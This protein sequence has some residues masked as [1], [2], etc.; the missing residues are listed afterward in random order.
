ML[1]NRN[2]FKSLELEQ[3][4]LKFLEDLYNHLKDYNGFYMAVSGVGDLEILEL[5]PIAP[6]SFNSD[7]EENYI[8]DPDG[9]IKDKVPQKKEN[10]RGADTL[11]KFQVFE[12]F[13][14]RNTLI[15]TG[16]YFE[17][18]RLLLQKIMGPDEL[19]APGQKSNKIKS[20]EEVTFENETSLSISDEMMKKI[21][22]HGDPDSISFEKFIE[23]LEEYKEAFRSRLQVEEKK[24]T[25]KKHCSDRFLYYLNKI[26]NNEDLTATAVTKTTF[27]PGERT[28][29]GM[30]GCN[31]S[32]L[33][34]G[35]ELNI[36]AS[37]CYAENLVAKEV[38]S[39]LG[40]TLAIEIEELGEKFSPRSKQ[41]N[42]KVGEIR[43]KYKLDFTNEIKI[44]L[45]SS[46]TFEDVKERIRKK[47]EP[48]KMTALEKGTLF[49]LS[50][51]TFIPICTAVGVAAG[52]GAGL[53]FPISIPI[54]L[55]IGG[56]VGFF[57][58]VLVGSI[59]GVTAIINLDQ[60]NAKEEKGHE[61]RKDS[62]VGK[63]RADIESFFLENAMQVLDDEKLEEPVE[64]EN[65]SYSGNTIK[66]RVE[67]K[68]GDIKDESTV[69]VGP[70]YKP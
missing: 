65:V 30:Y 4:K 24:K 51:R 13:N 64:T 48:S 40:T 2:Q 46:P 50:L 58:G 62:P 45:A 32:H 70:T 47:E 15:L 63:S 5:P 53:L 59:L 35:Q 19:L 21:I 38:E 28:L 44:L 36:S 61:S 23:S 25:W 56:A 29:K 67:P 16:A 12:S 27:K 41:Y 42:I 39:L 43:Q 55:I 68:P 8:F 60:P 26:L 37:L 57:A 33:K 17:T 18:N 14:F 3:L 66:T 52:F 10:I 7:D 34:E 1:S 69:D 6:N 49:A 22:T 9:N 54:T 20:I 11:G 31:V